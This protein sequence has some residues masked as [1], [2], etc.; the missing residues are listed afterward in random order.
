L[1]PPFYVSPACED[2][3]LWVL[4]PDPT[5]RATAKDVLEHEWCQ[6]RP[7][8]AAVDGGHDDGGSVGGAAASLALATPSPSNRARS[9]SVP[10]T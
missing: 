2:L 8:A 7:S 6:Q 9:T 3:L 5:S 4:H 1:H 10:N